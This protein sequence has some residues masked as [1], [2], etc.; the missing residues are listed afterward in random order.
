MHEACMHFY[1]LTTENGVIT[2]QYVELRHLNGVNFFRRYSKVGCRIG[3]KRRFFF[4]FC[5][6]V[7][8][9]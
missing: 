3:L 9:L 6:T 4:F 7:D 1:T 8:E 2:Y 5:S